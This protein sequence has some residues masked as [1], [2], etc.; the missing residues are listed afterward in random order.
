MTTIKLTRN[1]FDIMPAGEQNVRIS[2][3][4]ALPPYN[5]TMIE[6]TIEDSKGTNLRSTFKFDNDVSMYVFSLIVRS[7][8]EN[9][10]IDEIQVSDLP[11]LVNQFLKVEIKHTQKQSMKYPDRMNTF[12]NI[13]KIIG[14]GEPFVNQETGEIMDEEIPSYDD[15]M[16]GL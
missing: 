2:K 7:L 10:E 6:M 13:C 4:E 8:F 12:A 15:L 5:P 16:S 1:Q 14:K 9:D 11:K 3:V